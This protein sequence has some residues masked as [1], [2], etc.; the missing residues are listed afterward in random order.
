MHKHHCKLFLAVTASLG[1][2]RVECGCLHRTVHRK[3]VSLYKLAALAAGH[4]E[5][6]LENGKDSVLVNIL[7][8]FGYLLCN[9]V[10]KVNAAGNVIGKILFHPCLGTADDNH[11][12]LKGL[13][14]GCGDVGLAVIVYGIP[15][16]QAAHG[17][18]CVA[19]AVL[20]CEHLTD[21]RVAYQHTALA[22]FV[23]AG[24]GDAVSLILKGLRVKA[25]CIKLSVSHFYHPFC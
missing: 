21:V 14:A 22:D 1:G 24:A 23:E 3:S 11:A 16:K 8:V 10:H 9:I 6:A 18:P 25:L 13:G 2:C 17:N 19:G 4:S 20:A 12:L 5:N 7:P 15:V